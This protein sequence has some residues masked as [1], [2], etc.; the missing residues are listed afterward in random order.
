VPSV[1]CADA[2]CAKKTK[3]DT[4]QSSTSQKQDGSFEIHY[5]DGSSVKGDVFTETVQVAGVQ[6]TGQFFSPVTSMAASFGNDP[7]DG[8]SA[9]IGD[10][11]RI[12]TRSVAS[13][14]GIPFYL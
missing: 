14:V 10:S 8:V 6:V 3:F 11:L 2:A 7:I 4:S 9:F 13:R 1:D 5:G 12:L